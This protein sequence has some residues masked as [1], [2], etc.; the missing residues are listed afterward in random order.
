[1]VKKNSNDG[2]EN[3]LTSHSQNTGSLFSFCALSGGNRPRRVPG[4]F[5][6][7]SVVAGDFLLFIFAQKGSEQ[8]TKKNVEAQEGVEI[9]CFLVYHED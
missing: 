3:S 7:Y 1:M 4:G 9:S 2:G 8:G 5:H 6:T